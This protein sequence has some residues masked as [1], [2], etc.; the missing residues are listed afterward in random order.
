MA[1]QSFELHKFK[2]SKYLCTLIVQLHLYITLFTR[3]AIAHA[4]TFCYT[5]SFLE[6]KKISN[7]FE[8]QRQVL[9]QPSRDLN[10]H[11]RANMSD[12]QSF[13]QHEVLQIASQLMPMHLDPMLLR[14]ETTHIMIESC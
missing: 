3:L 11:Y 10:R 1:C 5:F 2:H 8:T 9:L 13:K 12:G 7:E 6:E 4:Y 14:Q